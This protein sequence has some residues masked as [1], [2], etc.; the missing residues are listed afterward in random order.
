MIRKCGW[1]GVSMCSENCLI[2][3]KK[4]SYSKSFLVL[5]FL[6]LIISFIV[7]YAGNKYSFQFS[8]LKDYLYNYSFFVTDNFLSFINP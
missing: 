2:F 6:S 7:D 5:S 8:C 4:I 1:I 3:F